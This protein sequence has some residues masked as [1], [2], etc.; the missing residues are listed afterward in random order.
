MLA[1]TSVFQANCNMG[2][3]GLPRRSRGDSRPRLS[4]ERSASVCSSR[5][6]NWAPTATCG[7]AVR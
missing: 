1:A 5:P 2:E 4:I 7:T 6:A 3:P